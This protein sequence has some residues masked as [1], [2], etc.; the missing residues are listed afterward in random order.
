M[1]APG[2][3]NRPGILYGFP[4]DFDAVGNGLHRCLLKLL[5]VGISFYTLARTTD[6]LSVNSKKQSR[7]VIM[8]MPFV[9]AATLHKVSL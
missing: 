1:Y 6:L 8:K 7:P 4:L 2:F 3:L 9:A 5:P